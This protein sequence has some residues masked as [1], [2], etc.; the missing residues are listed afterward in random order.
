MEQPYSHH[1]PGLDLTMQRNKSYQIN[2]FK[3][4]VQ[5]L[6]LRGRSIKKHRIDFFFYKMVFNA[7]LR[8][9]ILSEATE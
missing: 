9:N 1:A 5:Y 3:E 8:V 2:I 4:K 7:A 6:P